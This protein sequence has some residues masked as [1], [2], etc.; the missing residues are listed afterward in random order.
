MLVAGIYILFGLAFV[1]AG[2]ENAQKLWLVATPNAHFLKTAGA[3]EEVVKH[4]HPDSEQRS[5][6]VPYVAEVKFSY[7]SNGSRFVSNTLS[8][9]CTWCTPNEVFDAVGARPSQLAVGTP[10]AVFVHRDNPGIAY[11]Q[12]ATRSDMWDQ[13]GFTLLWLVIAP[14]FLYW[15]R[16]TWDRT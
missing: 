3:V 12:L 16:G 8:P 11:M 5:R 15:H 9:N 14:L 1:Y 4:A 13:L 6:G 10:V 7:A 2:V